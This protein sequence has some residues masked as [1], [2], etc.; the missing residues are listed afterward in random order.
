[1]T[2]T[3][4]LKKVFIFAEHIKNKNYSPYSLK[5][6]LE[7]GRSYSDFFVFKT[8]LSSNIFIAEN[9]FA[10]LLD[11][12]FPVDHVFTF[13]TAQGQRLDEIRLKTSDPFLRV[14][15]PQIDTNDDYISFTHHICLDGSNLTRLQAEIMATVG[16]SRGIQHRG[17]V[18]YKFDHSS[19]G[20]LVHGNF[21]GI[22]HNSNRPLASA[23]QRKEKYEFTSSYTY[24]EN[25]IYHLVFNNP[26]GKTLAIDV[27]DRHDNTLIETVTLNSFGTQHVE[28]SQQKAPITISSKLPICRPIV[29]KSPYNSEGFDV[30]H[31]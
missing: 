8:S 27:I 9:V 6:K 22:K 13:Y 24:G 19:I 28:I 1:M 21:G 11:E 4:L 10:L 16:K 3:N 20:S 26:T 25:Y 17:Y 30:F 14:T 2:G 18:L 7:L 23:K 5:S 12:Q 31:A 15:F 29:F